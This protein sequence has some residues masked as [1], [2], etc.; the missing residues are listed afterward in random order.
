MSR[1]DYPFSF[2][3][4]ED[5]RFDVQTEFRLPI[6]HAWAVTMEANVGED[7]PNVTIELNGVR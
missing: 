5:I 3:N 6:R 4:S 7:R 1:H 2:A